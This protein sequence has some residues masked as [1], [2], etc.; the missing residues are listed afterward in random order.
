[1]TKVVHVGN[2]ALGG[3]NPVWVQSMTN[4]DT[5]D[6]AATGAQIKALAEA[7]CDIVRVSV[8][9]ESCAQ[10]VRQLVDESPVPLVADIHFYHTWAIKSA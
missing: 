7:G 3:D 10:A 1:M 8:Y 6:A 2:L 4:T 9:D 5:R